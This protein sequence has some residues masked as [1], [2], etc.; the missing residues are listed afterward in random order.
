MFALHLH[1]SWRDADRPAPRSVVNISA[2]SA[3]IVSS[4]RRNPPMNGTYESHGIPLEDYQL[5]RR[6]HQWQRTLR[7][8]EEHARRWRL[9]DKL[10]HVLA[11]IEE[12]AELDEQRRLAEERRAQER[13][14]AHEQALER[15]RERLVQAHRARALAAQ[16]EAWRL[17]GEIRAFCAVVRERLP[18]VSGEMNAEN[19]GAWLGWAEPARTRSIPSFI[20]PE[21]HRIQSLLR[22]HCGRSWTAGTL[23]WTIEPMDVVVTWRDRHRAAQP[24]AE[25]QSRQ[26]QT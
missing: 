19:V 23:I 21:C 2:S 18:V 12:R 6:D 26:R 16:I 10:A 8:I 11:E 24:M 20:S 7:E 15:A 17:A 13:R 25:R 1:G 14:R 3:T 4:L 22:R 5:T 9:E